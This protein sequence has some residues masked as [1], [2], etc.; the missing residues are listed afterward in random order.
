MSINRKKHHADRLLDRR[1]H[2]RPRLCR[3]RR[4]EGRATAREAR[5]RRPRL[6]TRLPRVVGEGHRRM[7]LTPAAGAW[8]AA[9]VSTAGAAPDD[10]RM[11]TVELLVRDLD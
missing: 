4:D 3:R 9:S 5:R 10:T 8:R 6:G 1:R 7:S 11:D 2:P